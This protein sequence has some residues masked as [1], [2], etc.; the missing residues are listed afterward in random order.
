MNRKFSLLITLLTIYF[1]AQA[2]LSQTV[3]GS[4]IDADSKTPLVGVQV[5]LL[6]SDPLKG[7]VS[8]V[9]GNFTIKDV[10][11]GRISL[12]I[13][14]LGYEN[15]LIPDI[16]VISAKETVLE[17]L[18]TESI[19]QMEEVVISA[20]P[21]KEEPL[22]EMSIVS[23][24]S[25]SSNE[26]NRYAGGFNDPV[27]I[28]SNYAGVNNSQDGSVDIIVRGNSP[29]YIQWRLEG[30]QISNPSHFGDP[31]GLGTGA[32]SA[33]N[34]HILATSDFHTGAFSPEFGDVL[35]GIYDVKLRNGNN[36]KFEGMLGVGILG[37]D[38]TLEGP[39]KKDYAGSFLV[40]YRYAT[41]SL[42]DQ[43][44]L[45]DI[46]GIP[47]FQDG[48]FKLN[49]PTKKFGSFSI[50]GL[51]GYS[52]LDFEDVDPTIFPTP[53]DNGLNGNIREDFTKRAHLFN[54]GVNHFLPINR[55]S[56]LRTTLAY[57]NEGIKDDILEHHISDG[58][59]VDSR[60]NYKSRINKGIYRI[61]MTYN[62][63]LNERNMLQV[64]SNLALFNHQFN[65]SRLDNHL[66]DRISL[67]SMNENIATI[68]NFIGWKYRMNEKV[69]IVSGLH[70][71]NVPFNNKSTLEPRV[72]TKWEINAKN[73]L[74]LGYGLHS[75]MESIHHYFTR[76]EQPDG[77]V[78][79]PNQDL[80]LLK[81]H[82]LVL[83]YEKRLSKNIRM[84]T[85][86][87]YQY[88]YNLPVEN[89]IESNFATINETVDLQ[90]VDL[91]NSGTGENYG[92][93]LT[94]ERFFT[95]NYYFM[96]NGSLFNS[97][98]TALDGIKRNTPFNS[99]YL[100][101]ALFG[102]EYHGLGKKRNQSLSL[103]AKVFL[104]GGRRTI[105]LLRDNDGNLAVD[106]SNNVYW[107]YNKAYERRLEDIYFITLA[108]SYK[109]NKP[110]VT[111]ELFLNLDNLTN[112]Q[113]RL[114]EFY[115]PN[116]PGNIGYRTTFGLFPNLMYRIYF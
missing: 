43:I 107:D 50:F 12:R 91:I 36:Q 92:I 13:S 109:W 106:P 74:R 9:K 88:L 102:K 14:Y 72:A 115:A 98:Y 81:A 84:K 28:L 10:P 4:V 90:F 54:T 19:T 33:L 5:V 31:A 1:Q 71:M 66:T 52:T 49:L 82:H 104:G 60:E 89:N 15:Q 24:R 34:N 93:E 7:A 8:D 103:N 110:N 101:N 18:L 78:I 46:G 61:N 87:Y 63:K 100:V 20:N 51:S 30:V 80:G 83:G 77:S 105:P 41:I 108:V 39:F 113:T 44:G 59:I 32:P 38:L 111:H 45:V 23:S 57:S 27:R 2:Q 17:I 48:A 64:G 86:A 37:T 67:V 55:N 53:G 16:M 99:N 116:K 40:N 25:I 65:V 112:N 42:I 11:I 96:L 22:N 73:N 114:S 47:T 29:K 95:D 26:T 79:T 58:S 68:R 75:T 69:T 35:S 97:T 70:N 21:N 3:R 6:N 76:V 62:N 56:Y 94:L 85:E